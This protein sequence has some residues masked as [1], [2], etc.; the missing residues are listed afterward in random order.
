MFPD[1]EYIM[2][3]FSHTKVVMSTKQLVRSTC[4]KQSC[5]M[6][7]MYQILLDIDTMISTICV[8]NKYKLIMGI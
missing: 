6:Q 2:T 4:V 7:I 8:I 3:L 1:K 5:V